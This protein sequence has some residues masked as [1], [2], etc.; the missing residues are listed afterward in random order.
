MHIVVKAPD[1]F[2]RFVMNEER[3][4]EGYFDSEMMESDILEIRKELRGLR[5]FDIEGFINYHKTVPFEDISETLR[6]Y[7]PHFKRKPDE[8][9][10]YT[11]IKNMEAY[12]KI[13]ENLICLQVGKYQNIIY[14]TYS[15]N[16]F[17]TKYMFLDVFI[18]WLHSE[19]NKLGLY[20]FYV[21]K[22]LA[23]TNKNFV[24][25]FENNLEQTIEDICNANV[26]IRI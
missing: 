22:I 5:N 21:N 1:Y 25:D 8:D 11:Y 12:K 23:T 17:R 6:K 13:I 15:G 19:N 4:P 9:I 24:V 7:F 26:L 16:V 14:E 2:A 10:L 20:S 3:Q 18:N